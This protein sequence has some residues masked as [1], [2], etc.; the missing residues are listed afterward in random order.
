[1]EN[2]HAND[3][4]R[5]W[6]GLSLIL[7]IYVALA[8]IRYL[9]PDDLGKRDQERPTSYILDVVQNDNWL[10]P[11]DADG[12]ISSKPPMHPWI[13]AVASH[14]LGGV[15]RPA[16][17]FPSLLSMLVASVVLYLVGR[18][19]IGWEAALLA[20]T[21][22][23]LSHIGAKMMGIVRTDPLFGCVVLLNALAAFRVWERGSG[24]TL[25]WIIALVNTMTKG[26]LGVILALCGL[27]AVWW[28]RR[29]G[30][31]T[32][33]PGSLLP[34][35]VFWVV[36]SLGWLLASWWVLGD[37]VIAE[38][39]GRE[40]M[41]HAVLG[42][43]GEPAV[44]RLYMAPFY[45]LT[46]FLPW[47]LLT[48]AAIVRVIRRPSP[49]DE[50]R[51]FDR[52]LVCWILAGLVIFALV[53]H[54]RPNLIFPLVPPSALLAGS[55]LA[56][57]R[58]LRGARRAFAASCVLGAVLLPILGWVY[59]VLY[60]R[61]PGVRLGLGARRLA[62]Q[63]REEV[64]PEFPVA[65]ASA[66]MALQIHVGVWRR[67]AT[68]DEALKL[69]AAPDPAFVA[70]RGMDRFLEVCER[71]GIT[72]HP[73]RRW[74]D[75]AQGQSIGIVGNREHLGWYDTMTGWV[76]P[77]AITFRGVRPAGGKSYYLDK[78]GVQI[79]GGSFSVDHDGGGG[80]DIA[81]LSERP[82]VLRLTLRQGD[83]A[84]REEH[85]VDGGGTLLLAWPGSGQG[86]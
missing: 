24:W 46:R 80:L 21:I 61:D 20:A 11:R 75:E 41:R 34:G 32:T 52:F 86:P 23:L 3:H 76:A 48:V 83:R 50:R 30:H 9:T 33:L 45:L 70:V 73:V 7:A 81:N 54:Q 57:V 14:A 10:C 53:G 49:D 85:S 40:L 59:G 74:D 22:F 29:T 82:A 51:R 36:A 63:L 43:A 60:P 71:S 78:G 28:E 66:P 42:D 35:L 38:V 12:G 37:E 84:W 79:N 39:I 44:T 1:M 58:W 16:W 68:I 47:S 27:L 18:R 31:P 62:Q 26:P 56:D 72:A 25:F 17:M 15:V 8:G 55:M 2:G 4:R 19:R 67:Q 69:L 5:F 64:G 6:V 13:A 65:Y 77:F